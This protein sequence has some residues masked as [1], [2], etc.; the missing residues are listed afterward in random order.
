MGIIGPNG[1][2]KTTLITAFCK[3]LG[4]KDQI[5]S[6][7]FAIV[8]IYATADSS[9][10]HIDLYRLEHL[11]EAQSIGIEDY[12]YKEDWTFIEWPQLIE[13]LLPNKYVSLHMKLEDEEVRS[14]LMKTHG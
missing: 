2:G 11:Q 13:P 3:V 7:T 1:V 8:N 10:N 12:L 4:S 6:P 5:S 9:L 14:V